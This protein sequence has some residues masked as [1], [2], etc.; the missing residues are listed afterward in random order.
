MA[1]TRIELVADIVAAFVAH[2]NLPKSELPALI[3]AVHDCIAGL[4]NGAEAPAA[5]LA[6]AEKPTPAVSIRKSLTDEHLVCLEDGEHFKSLKRHLMTDH[7][8]TPDQYR[9]R[10]GLP[11]DYPMVA[12]AYAKQRSALAKSIGLGRKPGQGRKAAK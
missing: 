5:S 4:E 2:N 12:P 10:W 7:G 6:P 9:A 8:L 3:S 1:E 11:M